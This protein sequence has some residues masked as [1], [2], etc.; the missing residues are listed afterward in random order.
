MRCEYA[1]PFLPKM[2]K[3]IHGCPDLAMG[4]QISRHSAALR[5]ADLLACDLLP[6][7]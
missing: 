7:I 5:I 3:A 1:S 4:K 6:R 2:V